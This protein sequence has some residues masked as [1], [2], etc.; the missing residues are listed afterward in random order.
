MAGGQWF[1]GVVHVDGGFPAWRDAGLPT[2]PGT[3]QPT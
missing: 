1:P 2:E 3:E